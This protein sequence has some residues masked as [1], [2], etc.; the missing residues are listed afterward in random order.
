[1][2]ALEAFG[3]DGFHAGQAHALGGPVARTLAV[4]G[5]GDDDQRLLA[6]M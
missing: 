2:D 6:F 5:A 1:V 3:H 4:V